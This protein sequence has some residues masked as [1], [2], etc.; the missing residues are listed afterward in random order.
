M[1]LG[2]GLVLGWVLP[3]WHCTYLGVEHG[4]EAVHVDIL[5]HQLQGEA[6]C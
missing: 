4:V 3:T 2:L 5:A 6:G 1:E